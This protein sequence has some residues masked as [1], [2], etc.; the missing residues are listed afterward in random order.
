MDGMHSTLAE[1]A[2][3]EHHRVLVGRTVLSAGH[4]RGDLGRPA[5]GK[6]A[7]QETAEAVSGDWQEQRTGMLDP[8]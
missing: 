1:I 7:G 2:T 8:N 4:R 6:A 5:A 3:A